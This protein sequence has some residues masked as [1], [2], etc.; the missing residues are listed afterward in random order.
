MSYTRTQFFTLLVL[1]TTLL[2]SGLT[3]WGMGKEGHDTSSSQYK[4]AMAFYIISIF[5]NI[6]LSSIIVSV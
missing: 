5:I 2:V 6:Y 3:A 4:A 1:I